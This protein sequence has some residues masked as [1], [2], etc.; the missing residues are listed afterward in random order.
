MEKV[1]FDKVLSNVKF[2]A[3][4]VARGFVRTLYGAAVAGLILTAVYGFV[5]IKSETG[6]AAVCDFVAAA[7][8]LVVAL[9]NMYVLGTKKRGVKK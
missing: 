4:V 8:T 7:A 9:G 3:C 1:N 5:A 6:Y 2:H